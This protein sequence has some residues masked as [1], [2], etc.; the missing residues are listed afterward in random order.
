MTA[1]IVQ[2]LLSN[3]FSE[4][5]SK[6]G[7]SEAVLLTATVLSAGAR[8]RDQ[9]ANGHDMIDLPLALF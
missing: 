8:C 3:N 4:W 6:L 2:P 7:G 5:P 9:I 1:V